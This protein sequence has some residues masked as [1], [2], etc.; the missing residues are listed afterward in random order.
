MLSF[1]TTYSGINLSLA[2]YLPENVNSIKKNNAINNYGSSSLF[3][4]GVAAS[5]FYKRIPW[6][7]SFTSTSARALWSIFLI[8]IPSGIFS[9]IWNNFTQSDL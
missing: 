1:V 4:A 9:G 8:F 7:K 5:V 3:L 6:I 2:P